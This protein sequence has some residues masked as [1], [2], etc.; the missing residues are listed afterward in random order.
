LLVAAVHKIEMLCMFF[1][2]DLQWIFR[3]VRSAEAK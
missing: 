3:L 1:F 2:K